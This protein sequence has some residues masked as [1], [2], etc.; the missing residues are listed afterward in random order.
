M[1]QVKYTDPIKGI[2]GKLGQ[3]S[4]GRI[5][6]HRQ[7]T[8]GFNSKGQP[9]LGP[10]EV[11]FYHVHEGKWSEAATR[12]RELFRKTAAIAKQELA[13]PVLLE[14]WKAAFQAQLEKPVKGKRYVKLQ[15]FVLAQIRSRLKDSQNN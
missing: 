4:N 15:T 9:I 6:V 14:Q 7:K 10:Q 1:G 2:Q 3:A 13:D 11:Y 8:F 5:D 12:N